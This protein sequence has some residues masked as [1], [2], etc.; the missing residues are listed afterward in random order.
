M[1]DFSQLRKNLKK[2]FS[3]FKSLK[4][5]LLGD[6]ST[7]FL[8]Q[9]IR[10]EGFDAELD[11]QI[12]EADFNQ[13]EM[14]VFN[15]DSEMYAFQPDIIVL[16]LSSHKLFNKYN[17]LKVEQQSSLA[18]R[19]IENI[20]AIVAN[21]SSNSTAKI[22]YYNYNEIDDAVFGSFATK[23]ETSFLY[24][25]R[26]LNF[27]LMHIANRN[28]NFYICDLASIQNQVGR[29]NFFHTS[30]YISTEMVVSLNVL[31]L[32]AQK[33]V[34][35]LKVLN[36]KL[37][38]CVILD[39]DNTVWGGIIGDDGIENIQIGSLGIGK[40]FTEFQYW[41]KKLKNRGIIVAVCSKNTE[42]IAKEPFEKHPDMVLRLEDISVFM[43]NWENK[44][45]NIRA[46]QRILN[47]GFDSMVFLDDN[48]FERNL[49]RENIPQITVPELPEDPAEYLEYLYT[50]NLFETNSFS[51]E[52][53][54]RTKLYQIEAQR[55]VT[56]QK[57]TNEDDFLK[58]LDMISVV[59]SFTKFNIPRVAQLSQ[60][61]N[62]F[63]LR[64]VRYT[65]SDI[66]NLAKSNEYATFAFTLEDK[67]GDNGLIAVVVLKKNS[68]TD[69]FI[70]SWFMSCRVL[71]RGM[72]N[73]MLNTLVTYAKT[74]GFE[75]II[76]EYIPTPKNEIVK[77]HYQNLGFEQEN[78]FWFLPLKAYK[79]R[80]NYIT[81][82]LQE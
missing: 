48:P 27:E 81:L 64:T 76:G 9:A 14:Q 28:T 7:Q 12:W 3:I 42:S 61:S 72:E 73:F 17:K 10:G 43:A 8:S 68:E 19:E 74:N 60:R 65:E 20:E 53:K 77:D 2:D 57:F 39:L 33:T 38:K 63:N 80:T 11:L 56:K 69:L 51:D 79:E 58:S 59:A 44:A 4:V 31:P 1:K 67:F 5:A 78:D 82:K 36:G 21:I 50:L 35:I 23:T 55:T 71:K 13:I 26:K 25:L 54:E 70:E 6:T 29:A 34:D 15:S 32:V 46:I 52:D 47:I 37:K 41:I 40:A 22:I 66:E 62:Q 30:V 18:T 49:V 24:Q 16:F 45:D 75:R